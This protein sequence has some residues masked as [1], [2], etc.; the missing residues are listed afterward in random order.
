MGPASRA[1]SARRPAASGAQPRRV[2][3]RIASWRPRRGRARRR[4]ARAAARP[5]CPARPARRP[6]DKSPTCKG[7]A[8]GPH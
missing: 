2:L 1:R 6:E 5:A 3:P 8:L 4:S 7:H